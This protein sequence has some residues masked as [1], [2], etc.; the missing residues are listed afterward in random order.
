MAVL[1]VVQKAVLR[2]FAPRFIHLQPSVRMD[3]DRNRRF[4]YT[5]KCSNG[6][7]AQVANCMNNSDSMIVVGGRVIDR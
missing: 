6:C 1:G 4:V 5:I 3:W 2:L 7:L